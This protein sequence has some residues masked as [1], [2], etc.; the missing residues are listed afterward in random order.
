MDPVVLDMERARSLSA[1][2]LLLGALQPTTP[3]VF[4]ATVFFA[5]FAAAVALEVDALKNNKAS[6]S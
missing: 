1:R 2:G 3:V 6:G 4:L 5:A